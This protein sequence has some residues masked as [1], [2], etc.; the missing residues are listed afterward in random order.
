MRTNRGA[1][2]RAGVPALRV[3]RSE[4]TNV[5]PF[6]G[7]TKPYLHPGECAQSVKEHSPTETCWRCC[8][9]REAGALRWARETQGLA[10]RV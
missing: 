5:V 6:V 3:L 10:W 8:P 9:S 7:N 1:R 4:S 2:H